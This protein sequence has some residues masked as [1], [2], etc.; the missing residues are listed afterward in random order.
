MEYLLGSFTTFALL[1]F[2]SMLFKNS[3]NKNNI[4]KNNVKYSQ[5]HIFMHI[6]PLLPDMSNIKKIK[7][8]QSLDYERKINV[9]IIILD[10]YAYWIKENQFYKAEMVNNLIDPDTTTT[11][12]TIGMDSI[13]LDKMLFIM[14]KLREGLD[15]DSGSTRNQ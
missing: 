4:N 3:I 9:K 13:Q 7:N 15:N 6:K 11:V 2:F 14:D 10:N 12:D 1:I 5:S 8:T